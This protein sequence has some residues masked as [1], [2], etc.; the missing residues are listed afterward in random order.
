[1]GTIKRE[2][3]LLYGISLGTNKLYNVGVIKPTHIYE[4]PDAIKPE[5][6]YANL[7]AIKPENQYA[8]VAINK[9]TDSSSRSAAIKYLEEQLKNKK[10]GSEQ[11]PPINLMNLLK[12]VAAEKQK[13]AYEDSTQFT[14]PK[15][16]TL[17]SKMQTETPLTFAQIMSEPKLTNAERAE[18]SRTFEKRF[19]NLR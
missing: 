10:L 12:A 18:A 4:N 19:A 2:K 1:M 8:T 6:P 3:N 11:P 7:D 15:F 5:N 9:F 14:K 16:K 13:T 17:S